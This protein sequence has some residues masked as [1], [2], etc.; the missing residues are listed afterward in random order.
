MRLIKYAD[1]IFVHFGAPSEV[2]G[3]TEKKKWKLSAARQSLPSLS[4]FPAPVRHMGT[5]RTQDVLKGMLDEL[6]TMV[7][8]FITLKQWTKF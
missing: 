4:L 5:G 3:R 2:Y 1:D 8:K 7:W 6:L